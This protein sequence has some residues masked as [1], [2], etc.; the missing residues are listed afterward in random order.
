[1][2]FLMFKREIRELILA[3]CFLSFGGLILHLRIHP[4][5]ESLFFWIPVFFAAV[6]TFILPFLFNWRKTVAS[7]YLFTWA[8]MIA[9]TVGMALM[10]IITWNNPVT[11][12][13]IIFKSTF[14]DIIIMWSKIFIAYRMLRF[15]WPDG[16]VTDRQNKG[17]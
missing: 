9:G 4:P 11:V 6:N 7:A 17:S 1:M 10:S 3:F 14:P 2:G 16:V 12:F 8:T 13:N 5:S 15:H